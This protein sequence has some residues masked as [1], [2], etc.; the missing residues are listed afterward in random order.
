MNSIQ[1]SRNSYNVTLEIAVFQEGEFRV[2]YSP[3]LDLAGQGK[4]D[5]EAIEDLRA[6]VKITVDWARENGTLQQ[7]LLQH[8][9]TLTERPK[10]I[11]NPPKFDPV[12]LK[13]KLS[14]RQFDTKKLAVPVYA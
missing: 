7:M 14:I 4:T 9:W 8:G 3:A 10:L 12:Y 2:A 11:Y 5:H 13:K 6:S 1:V